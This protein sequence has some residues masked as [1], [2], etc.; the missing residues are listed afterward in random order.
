MRDEEGLLPFRRHLSSLFGD[1]LA[2][3]RSLSELVGALQGW[4]WAPASADCPVGGLVFS[5]SGPLPP[6]AT[7][8]PSVATTAVR[9]PPVSVASLPEWQ[10]PVWESRP[11][12]GALFDRLSAA[13]GD[14][15]FLMG[16]VNNGVLLVPDLAAVQPFCVSNYSSALEERAQVSAVVSEEVR[17]GW[18]VPV[19]EP[20]QFV[21]PLGAVPKS[22]GGI[23]VIHDHSVPLGVGVNDHQ[24][25]VR[26]TWDSLDLAIKYL[27]PHV[28][29]ARLDVSSYYRHFMVY[30]SQWCLQ[31]FEWEGVFYVDS[32][33]QFGL[34]LAP[35]LAHRFTMFVKRVL[36]ANGLRAAVGVMDD[37]LLHMD[38]S[39]CVVMLAVA[40]ALLA[41]LGFVVNFK[42]GK[43]VMPARVVK[44]V[45]VVVNS[46]RFTVSLP[47]DK[48][49]VLLGDV[50]AALR[51]RSVSRKELQQLVGRMQWASRVVF[52]GRVFIRSLLDGLST[53]QHPGRDSLVRS[54]AV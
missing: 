29:M 4:G 50:A 6:T 39:L 34:P 37:F 28:F 44:L 2:R 17:Q 14:R 19:P 45:G 26:Y 15:D 48:L 32:H 33:V 9:A 25:Y 22:D 38:Y 24:V 42:P 10:Q 31:G 23:R 7:V 43:T 16:V 5:G 18:V 27:A 11:L 47:E 3:E 20:L 8:D 1:N 53:V 35:E 51:G 41:D 36:H 40:A 46:A 21:H 49:A 54:Y 30:P 52:G 12:N 13:D